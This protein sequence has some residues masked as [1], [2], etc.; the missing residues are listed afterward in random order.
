MFEPPFRKVNFDDEPPMIAISKHLRR[1]WTILPPEDTSYNGVSRF[2]QI[3]S[4]RSEE[5]RRRVPQN[6]NKET[7][8]TAWRRSVYFY[9]NHI[10][11]D[12][13]NFLPHAQSDVGHFH[14][15][16][17]KLFS[18]E[19]PKADG[20]SKKAVICKKWDT[21][22]LIT[23]AFLDKDVSVRFESLPTAD[24][25]QPWGLLG[26]FDSSVSNEVWYIRKN[27]EVNIFIEVGANSS[28]QG[29]AAVMVYA[30][31]CTRQHGA[32]YQ[33]YSSL[34]GEWKETGKGMRLG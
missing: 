8:E 26:V 5:E 21:N 31:L 17:T 19:H 29:I 7:V 13:M 18:I 33:D 12:I 23:P 1:A 28:K 3:D 34:S 11:F 30:P 4:W 24:E 25:N 20:N 15:P 9:W 10:F 16:D 6:L 32:E 22:I 2:L 14:V 27:F